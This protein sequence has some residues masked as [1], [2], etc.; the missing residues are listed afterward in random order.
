M[1]AHARSA[2]AALHGSPDA[3]E[4]QAANEWLV[5]F[6]GSS[7]AFAAARELVLSAEHHVAFYGA[8]VLHT[9]VAAEWHSMGESERAAVYEELW[10]LLATPTLTHLVLNRLALAL[11]AAAGRS[12][13]GEA[14]LL[15]QAVEMLRDP[16]SRMTALRLISAAADEFDPG[17]SKRL[18]SDQDAG[19]EALARAWPEVWA[20]LAEALHGMGWGGASGQAQASLDSQSN[21]PVCL[22][23]EATR[24]LLR[25]VPL[26]QSAGAGATAMGDGTVELANLS[27]SLS[28]WINVCDGSSTI[29][30]RRAGCAF[31]C[32]SELF[33]RKTAG[34]ALRVALP[35]MLPALGSALLRLPA[36]VGAAAMT[37]PTSAE[38]MEYGSRLCFCMCELSRNWLVPLVPEAAPSLV[39]ALSTMLAGESCSR[40]DDELFWRCVEVCEAV[41]DAQITG[42]EGGGS[43]LGGAQTGAATLLEQQTVDAMI[44]CVP[45]VLLRLSNAAEAHGGEA[46]CLGDWIGGSEAA[47]EA[48]ELIAAAA[49]D[50]VG[51]D[52]GANEIEDELKNAGELSCGLL[53]ALTAERPSTFVTGL[54]EAMRPALTEVTSLGEGGAARA[55]TLAA[56]LGAVVPT[57]NEAHGP[58]LQLLRLLMQSLPS[59]FVA[60]QS[61]R[62]ARRAHLSLLR[63]LLIVCSTLCGHSPAEGEASDALGFLLAELLS[64]LGEEAKSCTD[65]SAAQAA[66]ALLVRSLSRRWPPAARASAGYSRA[67]TDVLPLASRFPPNRRPPL[68]AAA[69]CAQLLPTVGA[70]EPAACHDLLSSL[71]VAW[72][73]LPTSATDADATVALSEAEPAARCIAIVAHLLVRGAL[74]PTIDRWERRRLPPVPVELYPSVCQVGLP[75]TQEP[76]ARVRPQPISSPPSVPPFSGWRDAHRQDG[77]LRP[78]L[79][80]SAG[81]HRAARKGRHPFASA[82][83][84]DRFTSTA[85]DCVGPIGRRSARCPVCDASIICYPARRWLCRSLCIARGPREQWSIVEGREQFLGRRALRVHRRSARGC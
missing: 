1:A 57:A 21:D 40:L 79:T 58:L 26:P 81:S 32:L 63:L 15:T 23:L 74:P 68:V 25:W 70:T 64:T 30:M 59:V 31:E 44:C 14:R 35:P 39:N 67:L 4:R 45:P 51:V 20:A 76:R 52:D 62:R 72:A 12:P 22:C 80:A 53:L 36:I 47:A 50:G 55:G 3:R 78:H 69:V 5:E 82:P 49:A 10:G 46:V 42:E 37:P 43:A 71:C 18:S 60:A 28:E 41:V 9:K 83:R 16:A 8:S 38:A 75:T 77:L 13:G 34:V 11:A 7:N 17:T 85:L 6:T 73:E 66:T 2:L 61:G 65:A 19:V 27:R 29:S 84:R 54:S 48:A 56:L 24:S 33:G